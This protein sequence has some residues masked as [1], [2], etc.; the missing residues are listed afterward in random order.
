M[1]RGYEAGVRTAQARGPARR[2]DRR[3]VGAAGRD[4]AG[5][6]AARNTAGTSPGV[7]GGGARVEL[8][9]QLQMKKQEELKDANFD[10]SVIAPEKRTHAPNG[11]FSALLSAT[12]RARHIKTI[13]LDH[14]FFKVLDVEV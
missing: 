11:F 14:P 7:A 8:G 10:Y 4:A 3:T 9:F 6:H 1:S 5:H 13:D 12:E 2:G